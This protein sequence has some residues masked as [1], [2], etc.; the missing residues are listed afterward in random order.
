[1][2]TLTE[3]ALEHGNGGVFTRTELSFW[4]GGSDARQDSVLKRALASGEVLRIH[5]GIYCL[6]KKYV[7]E[8]IDPFVLAQRILGPSYI[9]LET[10][11]SVHGWIPEAGSAITSVS[12]DRAREF[13]TPLGLFSFSRVP[14]KTLLTGV[15]RVVK[16][17]GGSYLLASPLKALADY[18]YV[19]KCDWESAEQVAARL[20][21]EPGILACTAPHEF[22]PLLATYSSRRVRQ[23][24]KGVRP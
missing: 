14:Q 19:K 6:A 5:R 21:I 24:L 7:R 15:R 22:G 10:A 4:I 11:L 3:A 20:Q 18:V 1:M 23:F 9:S 13:D 2:Q 17:P 12:L 16:D 8:E